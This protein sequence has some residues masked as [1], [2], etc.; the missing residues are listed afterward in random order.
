MADVRLRRVQHE[1]APGLV[2]VIDEGAQ[3]SDPPAIMT[4]L[5]FLRFCHNPSRISFHFVYVSGT[6][7]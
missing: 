7:K 2:F 6:P 1:A 5:A 4:R 3:Q